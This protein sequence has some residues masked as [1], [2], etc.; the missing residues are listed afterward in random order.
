M[1]MRTLESY[2]SVIFMSVVTLYTLFF[3]DLR[4]LLIDRKYDNIFY[5]VTTVCFFLF[6][7]EILVGSVCRYPYFLTFFFWLDL[8][9]TISML[10][11]I[12]WFWDLLTGEG[13]N[14]NATNAT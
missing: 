8:V 6:M 13:T 11:D 9:S 3:D 10:P 14:I 2:P 5:A 7:I 12:G 1:G 4:V